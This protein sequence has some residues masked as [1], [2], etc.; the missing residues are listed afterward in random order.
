MTTPARPIAFLLGSD[1]DLP[2]LESA[3]S[4][5]RELGVGFHVRI[6]SAHRTPDEAG[7]FARNAKAN[8]VR[9]LIGVAGMAAH[10]AG[11]LAAHSPLPVIGVPVDSGPLRGEDALLSTA[12]M[13]PGV[14]VAATGIGTAAARNAALF[15][16]R[17]LALSDPALATK[18]DGAR[19]AE[20]DKTLAKD[21]E[22]R[23]RFGC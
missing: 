20:R 14:P 23:A 22:V 15:A 7:E 21:R 13:P 6:L 5:L 18:V 4:T 3:F 10:L 19:A 17:I 9:V 12:M 2:V 11:A 1:S 16:A 8:G